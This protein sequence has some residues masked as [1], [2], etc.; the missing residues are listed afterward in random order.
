[1]RAGGV[2]PTVAIC[3]N[4]RL[5]TGSATQ[6]GW[7]MRVWVSAAAAAAA[8]TVDTPATDMVPGHPVGKCTGGWKAAHHGSVDNEKRT[9]QH[10]GNSKWAG[11]VQPQPSQRI[12]SP[13]STNSRSQPPHLQRL[14]GLAQRGRQLVLI[15]ALPNVLHALWTR[16]P[17]EAQASHHITSHTRLEQRRHAKVEET[18]EGR[19][20][21]RQVCRPIPPRFTAGGCKAVTPRCQAGRESSRRCTMPERP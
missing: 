18:R 21:F 17:P 1:M 4:Q 11:R 7:W 5:P 9:V 6:V 8:D 16:T 15:G 14:A 19:H 10:P 20:A 3:C 13:S 12:S 2:L